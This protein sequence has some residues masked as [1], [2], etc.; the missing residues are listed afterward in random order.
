MEAGARKSD[1]E[2]EANPVTS[3]ADVLRY[4]ALMMHSLLL[5][6]YGTNTYVAA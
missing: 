5:L 2:R 1:V 4:D 6:Y 3:K